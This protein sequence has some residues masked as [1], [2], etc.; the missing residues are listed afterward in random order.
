MARSSSSARARRLGREVE[1]RVVDALNHNGIPARRAEPEEDLHGG[2][3]LEISLCGFTVW[4][5]LTISRARLQ[6]KQG[7]ED[8]H[9]G[10]VVVVII[11]PGWSEEK[12]FRE[13]LWQ[14]V[15]SLPKGRAEYILRKRDLC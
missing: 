14:V 7:R 3:D 5:D 10:L 1:P 13:V 15:H 8:V 11:N 12:L 2:W 6:E 9:N 4:V